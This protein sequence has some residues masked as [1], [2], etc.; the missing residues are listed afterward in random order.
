MQ[1]GVVERCPDQS[2]VG[3]RVVLRDPAEQ[4][5]QKWVVPLGFG[6]ARHRCHTHMLVE[7]CWSSC[8]PSPP[9]RGEGAASPRPARA[10]RGRSAT[11]RGRRGPRHRPRGRGR[12]R[13]AP[14][15]SARRSR[16]ASASAVAVAVGPPDDGER[17]AERRAQLD[18]LARELD[19]GRPPDEVDVAAA[20]RAR[21]GARRRPRRTA[22]RGPRRGGTATRSG[23]HRR[24]AYSASSTQPEPSRSGRRTPRSIAGAAPRVGDE[25][26]H[27]LAGGDEAG[28][29]RDLDAAAA[30]VL[31]AGRTAAGR[32]GRSRA[33]RA[34]ARRRPAATAR[35][36]ICA[37][38]APFHS[39]R[40]SR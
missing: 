37:E 28:D 7:G 17:L 18:H 15:G 23:R 9:G 24:V 10:R 29:G 11:P 27:R 22:G 6:A 26:Q 35:T 2:G 20:T 36:S 14:C 21:R 40:E 30:G 3:V 38:A 8:S 33:A 1:A 13:G 16:P 34:P 19:L 4:L 31:D 39:L 32:A 5:G 25:D 12:P